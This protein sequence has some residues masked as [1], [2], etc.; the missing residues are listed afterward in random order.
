MPFIKLTSGPKINNSLALFFRAC[1]LPIALDLSF[2]KC[3]AAMK[4]LMHLI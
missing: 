4:V 3:S 1:S 2:P